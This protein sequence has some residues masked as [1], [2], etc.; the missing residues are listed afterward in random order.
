MEVFLSSSETNIPLAAPVPDNGGP[1]LSQ[2]YGVTRLALMP[3]DPRWVHAYWEIAPYTWQEA[4]RRVGKDVL[5]SG[6]PTLRLYAVGNEEQGTF[7]TFVNLGARNWYLQ[8]PTS[9]GCWRGEL[10]LALVDGRFVLLAISNVVQMPAG[11]VSDR[12]DEK[13]GILKMEWNRLFELSGG[14]RL[15]AGSLDMARMLLQRWNLLKTVSSW[16]G[17]LLGSSSKKK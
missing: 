10:G 14:G 3:R 1:G 4:E 17:S 9:G 8:A 2:D 7:D 6:R 16:S 5:S 11:K 15:G 13:W 12:V